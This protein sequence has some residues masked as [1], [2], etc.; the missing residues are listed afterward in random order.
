MIS[1]VEIEIGLLR[2]ECKGSGLDEAF[3]VAY[4]SLTALCSH[5]GLMR[6][7]L[8]CGMVVRRVWWMRYEEIGT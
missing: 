6:F 5:A 2:A 3:A 7:L 1:E 8:G 4:V